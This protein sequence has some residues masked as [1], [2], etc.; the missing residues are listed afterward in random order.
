LA[1]TTW[2][3]LKTYG[4]EADDANGEAGQGMAFISAAKGEEQ[5]AVIE[6]RCD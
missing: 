3:T 4:A 2:L 6:A 1:V 5:R